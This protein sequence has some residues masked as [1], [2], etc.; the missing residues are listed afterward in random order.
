MSRELRMDEKGWYKFHFTSN[1][2]EYGDRY[3][4]EIHFQYRTSTDE[5][6][7]FNSVKMLNDCEEDILY[8]D[9]VSCKV[10]K[11]TSVPTKYTIIGVKGSIDFLNKVLKRLKENGRCMC[12]VWSFNEEHYNTSFDELWKLAHTN[13]KIEDKYNGLFND[14]FSNDGIKPVSLFKEFIKK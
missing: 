6:K 3:N 4:Y 11:I 5:E 1:P 9:D 10:S 12:D 8:F 2:N 14:L 7:I 13:E